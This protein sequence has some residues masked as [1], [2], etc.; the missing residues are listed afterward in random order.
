MVD[1]I[2]CCLKERQEWKV[3]WVSR[4]CNLQ[5]HLLAKWA[6]W[7]DVV[8]LFLLMLFPSISKVVICTVDFS[9]L[10]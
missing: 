1:H 6:A 5:A 9:R 8:G 7:F 3:A 2:R 4:R 10:Y